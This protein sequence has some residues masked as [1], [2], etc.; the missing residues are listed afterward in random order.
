MRIMKEDQISARAIVN[1]NKEGWTITSQKTGDEHGVDIIA[2][3]GYGRFLYMECKGDSAS[4][5]QRE[6]YFVQSLGQIVTRM[7]R[8]KW[9]Y[10]GLAL[11]KSFQ[12]RL[13][14]IPWV[15]AKR[16]NV[17]VWLIDEKGKVDKYTWKELKKIQNKR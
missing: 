16:N 11:P 15:F 12:P 2:K 10:F 9:Q 7:S 4:G 3:K 13:S 8:S 17:F 1:L 5:P 6:S 14:R